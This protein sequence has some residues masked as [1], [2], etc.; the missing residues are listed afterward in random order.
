MNQIEINNLT[1]QYKNQVTALTDISFQVESGVFGLLG[2]NGSGKTTLMKILAT[3]MRPTSGSVRIGG[4]DINTQGEEARRLIG[5][6]PQE[7]SMYPTL[8]VFDFVC[9][10]AALKGVKDRKKVMDVLE[11]VDMGQYAGRRIGQLSGGMKRRVGIAQ[12]LAGDPRILIVDEPTAGLDPE[13]RVRF[14]SVLS[15]FA[16]DDKCVLLSTHIVEDV[17]QLC[18]KLAVLRKGA[19]FFSGS[20]E[21]LLSK[22]AGKVKIVEIEKEKDLAALQKKAVVLSVTYEHSGILARILDE[23]GE[24]P[25]PPVAETLEDAYVYCMGGKNYE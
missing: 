3:I 15:R 13:E 16:K 14:R 1:K 9:Y 5:Y 24:F 25:V 23:R 10:M 20:A 21:E 7:L 19:L 22:A 17:Y 11:Q 6:L 12:A 2:H 18:E 8:T 4:Y